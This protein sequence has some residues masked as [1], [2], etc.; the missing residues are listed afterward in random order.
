MICKQQE[1]TRVY[2]LFTDLYLEYLTLTLCEQH[3]PA[4]S[5]PLCETCVDFWRNQTGICS[6]EFPD[7]FSVF[8]NL[9]VSDL[10]T[11]Y[12]GILDRAERNIW[13]Y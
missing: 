5:W 7:K 13:D 8:S 3:F 1:V 2:I 10:E 11:R 9:L 6:C 12:G 4:S